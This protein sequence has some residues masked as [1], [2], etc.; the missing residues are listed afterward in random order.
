MTKTSDKFEQQIQRIHDLLERE[1]AVVTWNDRLPDPDNPEQLRQIDVTIKRD[2]T[3]IL[4]ECRIHKDS[5]DV[6]WIEEL[7]GK[8]LSMQADSV[9]AVS[10]SGFTKG[11][12]AKGQA[13]GILLRALRSLTEEEI[14]HWGRKTK[15]SL[16]FYEYT[17]VKIDFIFDQKYRDAITLEL[18]SQDLQSVTKLYAAFDMVADAIEKENPRVKNPCNFK[19][20]LD[21]VDKFPICGYQLR[22]LMVCA[23]VRSLVEEVN[24]PSVY[25][26]DSPSANLRSGSVVVEKVD[27]GD[28]EI[29]HS[30]NNVSIA[31]DLSNVNAPENCQFRFFET[32][33]GR[34]VNC[35]VLTVLGMY[36]TKMSLRNLQIGVG[37]L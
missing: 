27:L 13:H 14:C 22:K 9:I 12:V 21:V 25:I 2:D 15:I 32:D 30:S 24:I 6:K 1:G 11:A 17:N 4:I 37:F 7:I 35:E 3:L 20:A 23:S 10:A 31:V 5:Q 29:A 34:E 8:R 36:P 28:F 16:I 33:F 19:V 18:I 26:Y